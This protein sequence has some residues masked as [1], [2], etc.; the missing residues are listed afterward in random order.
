[1]EI[2]TVW[3]EIITKHVSALCGKNVE[4]PNVEPG[5]ADCNHSTLKGQDAII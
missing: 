4:F 1:M 3:S 5:V 2:I